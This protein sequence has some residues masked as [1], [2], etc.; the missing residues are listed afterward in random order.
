MLEASQMALWVK[1]APAIQEIQETPVWYLGQKDHLEQGMHLVKFALVGQSLSFLLVAKE[2]LTDNA[3]IHPFL[4]QGVFWLLPQCKRAPQNLVVLNTAITSWPWMVPMG[5]NLQREPPGWAF[6]AQGLYSW[7]SDSG[8]GLRNQPPE[9]Q[10]SLSLG[11]LL[12]TPSVGPLRAPAQVLQG[13]G[14]KVRHLFC[15]S[16]R[17]H[18]APILL[19]F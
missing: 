4:L 19:H 1:N 6:L 13:T 8:Q 11:G 3:L 18:A 7:R 10:P 15:A 2:P 16:L 17:S 5:Q 14:Q 12:G 9:A